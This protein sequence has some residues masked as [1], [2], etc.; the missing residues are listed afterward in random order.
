MYEQEL[1]RVLKSLL[2]LIVFSA[3]PEDSIGVLNRPLMLHCAAY[4]SS[5][6]KVLPVAWEKNLGGSPV[7]L[8][9]K[10]HQ[11]PN[12]SLLFIRLQEEDLGTYTCRARTG[13]NNI[14]TTVSIYKAGMYTVYC[15]ICFGK[16][17]TYSGVL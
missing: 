3:V 13:A 4:D 1:F 14:K 10:R 17:S 12:G 2:S 8:S 16:E 5:L 9:S 6:Q 11:M 15:D 7:A